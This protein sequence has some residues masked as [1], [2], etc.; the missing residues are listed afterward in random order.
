[1]NVEWK[2]YVKGSITVSCY[3]LNLNIFPPKPFGC[4]VW[5]WL[6]MISWNHFLG[7]FVF[8][9]LFL[10][11]G[12]VPKRYRSQCD[13]VIDMESQGVR[14]PWFALSPINWVILNKLSL[15]ALFSSWIKWAYR[16][17]VSI[18]WGYWSNEIMHVKYLAQCLTVN[19]SYW[20]CFCCCYNN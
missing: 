7:D 15:W 10:H 12:D 1:M 17:P 19:G 4:S 11:F 3:D 6:L 16:V 18:L 2:K 20:C 8:W 13:A 14:L 9:F 5:I